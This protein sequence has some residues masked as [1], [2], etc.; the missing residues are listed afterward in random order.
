MTVQ[1]G[2]VTIGHVATAGGAPVRKRLSPVGIA[3][4]CALRLP[5]RHPTTRLLPAPSSAAKVQ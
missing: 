1:T 3:S 4:T 2:T 5:G